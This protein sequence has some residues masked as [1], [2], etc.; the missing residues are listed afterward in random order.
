MTTFLH[1]QCE[2]HEGDVCSKCWQK[3]LTFHEFYIQ[4]E[5]IHDTLNKSIDLLGSPQETLKV[6]INEDN[7]KCE[8]Q[9][10]DDDWFHNEPVDDLSSRSS[11][12][13]HFNCVL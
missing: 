9:S 13:N 5:S 2:P 4:I 1:L 10:F 7:L 12:G 11:H 3:L 8:Q 6:E